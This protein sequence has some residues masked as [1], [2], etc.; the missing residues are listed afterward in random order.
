MFVVSGDSIVVQ[1]GDCVML[2]S[3]K[4]N[5]PLY[6]ARIGYMWEQKPAGATFHA[7]IFCRGINTVL[8]E[9]ADPHELFEADICENCPIGSIVRK[10]KVFNSF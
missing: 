3:A 6:I 7:H 9:T 4:P 5:E 2:N 1:P 10:T 8:G